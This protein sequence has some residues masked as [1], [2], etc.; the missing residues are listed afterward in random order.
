MSQNI[1]KKWQR[2]TEDFGASL[3]IRWDPGSAFPP[4]D[5]SSQLSEIETLRPLAYNYDYQVPIS[6][7]DN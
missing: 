4:R 3:P 6:R 7:S 1:A 5:Y 2:E